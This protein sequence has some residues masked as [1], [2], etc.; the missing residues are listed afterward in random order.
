MTI[1]TP[2]IAAAVIAPTLVGAFAPRRRLIPGMVLVLVSPGIL[3]VGVVLWEMLARP[4][5][6]N[7]LE[8]AISGFMLMSAVAIVPWFVLCTICCTIGLGIRRFVRGDRDRRVVA[9]PAL[10]LG[11]TQPMIGTHAGTGSPRANE[12]A[13]APEASQG[14]QEISPDGSIRVDLDVQEWS[15]SHWVNSPRVIETATGRVLLDLWGTDWDA[16]VSFPSARK[17]YLFLRRYRRGGV[18]AVDLDLA[19]ETYRIVLESNH[20]GPRS[21]APL[22]D[23]AAGL[24]EAS[25]RSCGSAAPSG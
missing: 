23:I 17:V 13:G 10:V 6:A 4:P 8:L 1:W 25:I 14:Y 3:Y 22:N 20:E 5:Q 2:L 24:E 18:L 9:Q 15:N 21:E 19:R 11:S 12:T 7:P 16:T